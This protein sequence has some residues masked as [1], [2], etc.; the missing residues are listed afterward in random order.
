MIYAN[1][2]DSKM[3]QTWLMHDYGLDVF[4]MYAMIQRLQ[5]AHMSLCFRIGLFVSNWDDVMI[6]FGEKD[7]FIAI[8]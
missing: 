4:Y 1:M 5:E 6:L 2:V 8:K 7:M 3:M